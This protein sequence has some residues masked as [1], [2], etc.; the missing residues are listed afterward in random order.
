MQPQHVVDKV[1]DDTVTALDG[2][3]ND[4]GHRNTLTDASYSASCNV[5]QWW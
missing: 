4:Y 2:R 3:P 1:S 5:V